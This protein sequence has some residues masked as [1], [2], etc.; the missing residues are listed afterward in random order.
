MVITK[1]FQ[2]MSCSSCSV[3]INR[4]DKHLVCFVCKNM[5]HLKCANID[6]KNYDESKN[7]FTC[8]KCSGPFNMILNKLD[9]NNAD[10]KSQFTDLNTKISS[11]QKQ[12]DDIE[13][14][15]DFINKQYEEMKTSYENLLKMMNDRDLFYENTKQEVN[16]LKEEI[17][18]LRKENDYIKQQQ[19]NSTIIMNGI[20]YTENENLFEISMKICA[21][22][23]VNV[24]EN[25]VYD[26]F[27]IGK[28]KKGPII[29]RFVSKWIRDLILNN[30]KKKSLYTNEIFP[31]WNLPPI[32][33]FVNELLMKE[34][35]DLFK[36]ARDLKK[37]GYDFVWVKNGSVY[38]KK[39]EKSKAI[40]VKSEAE[41]ALLMKSVQSGHTNNKRTE[42]KRRRSENEQEMNASKI[43]K[44]EMETE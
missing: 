14:F 4:N 16:F 39:N 25:Q 31:E 28:D 8:I 40:L 26:L 22:L 18:D 9:N 11:I 36:K 12:I 24:E 20:Y 2:K 21:F 23:S 13:K 32:Q 30:R 7:G 35:A 3:P 27:R 37:N 42:E 41:I 10:M 5:V 6:L 38:V 43:N 17:S 44:A 15:Q 34:K 19:L 1:E 33:I 29:I